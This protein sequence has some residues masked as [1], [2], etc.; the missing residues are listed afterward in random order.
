MKKS[1]LSIFA[2]ATMLLATGCSQ[3]EELVNGGE[4]GELVEVSF[5]IKTGEEAAYS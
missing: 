2:M 1:L 4:N 3:E 5:N